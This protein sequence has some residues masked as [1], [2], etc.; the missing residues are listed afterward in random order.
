MNSKSF[1][2]AVIGCG[3]IGLATAYYLSR[4]HGI[5]NIALID[6][7][8]PM[9]FTSA[10]SGENYRNWWPHPSMVSFTNRSIDLLE[11]IAR[12]T[13]NRINMNRRGY[14]LATRESNIDE[15]LQQ[16][17]DGLGD[18]AE[19]LLR[20]H[21][22]SQASS[23]ERPLKADWQGVREG[24]DILRNP[25]L[26][27]TTFPSYATDIQTVI[28]I[29]RG[30]DISGQQL[31]MHMLEYLRE[32]GA[33]RIN[34]TVKAIKH[35]G[36][37]TLELIGETGRRSIS[38][39]K[40]V[41]AAGPFANDIAR[42]LDTSLPVFN[43]FQQKI[44]FEDRQQLIP[45]DMPFS[46][47]LDG[48]DIDWLEDEREMLLEDPDFRWLAES[49]PGAI[50]CRPDGGDAGRWI[51]LGWAYNQNPAEPTRQLPLDDHYPDVVLR[52]AAR[53][54]PSLKAYYGQLP[55]NMHHYGGW[56]TM[57]EENWP[58]IGPMGVEGAFMNCALSGFGTMSAC[59]AGELCA[60][61]VTGAELPSYASDFSLSRRDDEAL[62]E[63]LKACN[64][65]IL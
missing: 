54:N 52:G 35:K 34:G 27:K 30:G 59:A 23:Y 33:Q 22:D 60:A 28:H 17:H 42:M 48:Q 25:D 21:D 41:N 49:M 8:Q 18:E 50:H 51:K 2:V 31:G 11:D 20:F 5:S 47:D 44:A 13:D 4:F 26:I 10:Q 61:W 39:G 19:S 14:A 53:L 16:L 9:A 63:Q 40:I 3:S 58:L 15:L 32:K 45:R 36:D 62:M 43:T 65:G 29:R 38:A 56:Y 12:E 46:I 6:C 57:T 37:F 64:K 55:R 24:V 7:G 1:D